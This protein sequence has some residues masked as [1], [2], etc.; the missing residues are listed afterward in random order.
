MKQA[1]LIFTKNLICGQVKTRLA[2][3]I[4]ND[5]ALTVYQHLLHHTASVNNYLPVDKIVFYSSTLEEQ[6][7]WNNEVYK[8]QLQ[9]GNDLGE[10]MQ[11]AFSYAFEQG[12]KEVAIIGTD[13]LDL[14]S[15]IIMNAFAYLKKHDVVIGPASDGGYYLLAMKQMNQQLF[16]NINWSTDQVLKQTLANCENQNLIVYQLPKLPDIDTENDSCEEQKQML[17]IKLT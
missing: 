9:L 5:M 16:K 17:Q 10:R 2:A 1:L 12:N 13:S 8:K 3:T 14:T 7:L 6:D 4:G 11:N 15:A